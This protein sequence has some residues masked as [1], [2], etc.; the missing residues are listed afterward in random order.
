MYAVIDIAGKQFKITKDQYIYT[1]KLSEEKGHAITFDKV[2]LL[3]DGNEVTVGTPVI[4]GAK[5][6]A[7]IVEHVKGDKILVFKKKRRKGYKKTQG[8]R[9]EYTKVL[10]K[11][12]SK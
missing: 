10:V 12:I 8:H 9:Q 3:D 5:V 11:D 1:P 6:A 2:L 7:E 4:K